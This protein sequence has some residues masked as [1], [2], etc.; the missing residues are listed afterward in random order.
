VS[1][2]RRINLEAK[3]AHSLHPDEETAFDRGLDNFWNWTGWAKRLWP[4][5]VIHLR[6]T[7]YKF[8]LRPERRRLCALVEITRGGSFSFG[9]V[10]EFAQQVEKLTGRRPD[11]DEDND[12]R[13]KWQEIEKRLAKHG[14]CTGI[15]LCGTVKQRTSITLPGQ[16]PQIGWCD[17]TKPNYGMLG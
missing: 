7:I 13:G 8:D 4:A 11:P 16:F 12:S 10:A 17:L 6:P 2:D 1:D 5:K 9:S 15:C 3:Y 14:R